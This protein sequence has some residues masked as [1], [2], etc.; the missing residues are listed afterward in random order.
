M[1][2]PLQISPGLVSDE[3]T[4]STP[5]NWA[6]G[7]NV[8]FRL[9][10]PES[11]GGWESY[12]ANLI[13]GVCRSMVAWIDKL[14]Q[15]NV[16]FGTHSGLYVIK[17]GG[18]YDITP[19]GLDTGAV[20]T[21]LYDGGYGSGGYGMGAYGV[22]ATEETAR[23]WSLSLFGENLIASPAGG[24]V[25]W[26][27]ND[28]LVPAEIISDAPASCNRVIVTS[29]RQVVAF[30]VTKADNTFN[31]MGI[32]ASDIGNPGDWSQNTN[33]NVFET[34]VEGGGFIVD[35]QLLGDFLLVWTDNALF[36]GQ[37]VGSSDQSYRFDKVASGCG[38][39][40]PQAAIV[41][42][43]TAYW[44][45]PDLR[46]F[47]Y[48]YGGVPVEI[49]CPISREF[50]ENVD[51]DQSAKIVAASIGKFGEVWWFYPDS[52]DVFA[53]N[54]LS[55]A[56]DFSAA[57][58]AKTNVTV[59]ANTVAAPDGTMTADTLTITNTAYTIEQYIPVN[60]ETTYTLSWYVKRGTATDLA[61]GVWDI[62]N[63]VDLVAPTSYYSETS[64]DWVRIS[65]T[66]TTSAG[67]VQ[68]APSPAKYGSSTGTAYLWG[69][70]L[71]TGSVAGAGENS[72]YISLNVGD[73]ALPWSKGPIARTAFIDSGPLAYPLGI[74]EAGQTYLHEKGNDA[75][76]AALSWFVETSAQYLGEGER[77]AL[78]RGV[79]PDFEAQQGDVSLTIKAFAYP[80]A[81]ARTKGPFTLPA[82]REKKDFI[83]E[84]RMVALRFS[85]SAAP[86]FARIG[87]P[88]FDVELLGER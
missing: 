18:L 26:W 66:F 38:L 42:N 22:G 11:I 40:G 85:A 25:Y 28:P 1:R 71:E 27:L 35:C 83:A 67:C 12:H 53:S 62:T 32:R 6:D 86:T 49:P 68:I 73:Q 59:T 74:D 60:P 39:I 8:R 7:D 41:V 84:G 33:D 29:N 19:A 43:Q 61:W 82:G 69:A 2:V 9:G 45:T 21:V 50:R 14:S 75:N 80:Q 64:A 47:A 15:V 16:A 58:W 77:R 57:A 10:R 78:V 23:T 36:L 31:P 70:R 54:M 44:M 52:R 76:G 46:F 4:Y 37:F 20:D 79:W 88:T 55:D 65:K 48:Q 13:T 30:G 3:T 17:S 63:S 5:G 87:K 51:L 24:G 34:A 72:R 56:N 81:T